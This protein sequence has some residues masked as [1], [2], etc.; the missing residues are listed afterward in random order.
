MAGFGQVAEALGAD[1]DAFPALLAF[2]HEDGA[3]L[4]PE[5]RNELLD[6]LKR[7]HLGYGKRLGEYG[8]WLIDRLLQEIP[9]LTKKE[10][11]EMAS[12]RR[13]REQK[14][15]PHAA[16]T[17]RRVE[18]E[19]MRPNET[20]FKTTWDGLLKEWRL[21]SRAAVRNRRNWDTSTWVRQAERTMA[22]LYRGIVKNSMAY[23]EREYPRRKVS[24]LVRISVNEIV[25]DRLDGLGSEIWTLDARLRSRLEKRRRRRTAGYLDELLDREWRSIIRSGSQD[26]LAIN[27]VASLV[28]AGWTG[29]LA[30]RGVKLAVWGTA[31][32]E[33]VR[34]THRRY[35]RSKPRPIGFNYARL[36]TARYIL[37]WPYDELC[38]EYDE[39]STCRCVLVPM[40]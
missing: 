14:P 8:R 21:R 6:E 13:E 30:K 10:R 1:A 24:R 23:A 35:G 38:R 18:S 7:C 12:L 15:S 40:D 19:L 29:G 9:P 26:T 25:T 27:E 20:R 39:I 4:T 17:Q 11:D 32:D 3:I 22:P 34:E 31:Q 2:A 5:W 33:C 36:S 28:N 37:R 16:Q